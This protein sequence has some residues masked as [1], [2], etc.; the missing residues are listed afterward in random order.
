[1]TLYK[2]GGNV[3]GAEKAKLSIIEDR[4]G[5]Q[6]KQ[7]L[8]RE[9]LNEAYR[10]YRK[11]KKVYHHWSKLRLGLDRSWMVIS[12]LF[13]ESQNTEIDDSNG[14]DSPKCDAR[15]VATSR[16]LA[17]RDREDTPTQSITYSFDY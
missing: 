11:I 4:Q 5:R 12:I 16:P 17:F 9:A 7:A 14:F 13:S 6:E 15:A 1:M 10:Q 8:L 2:C 3:K